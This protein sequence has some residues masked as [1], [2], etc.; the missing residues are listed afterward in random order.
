MAKIELL[1]EFIQYARKKSYQY[2]KK[3]LNSKGFLNK[4]FLENVSQYWIENTDIQ[5]ITDYKSFQKDLNNKPVIPADYIKNLFKKAIL[6]KYI[7]QRKDEFNLFIERELDFIEQELTYIN[8]ISTYCNRQNI[9]KK[10]ISRYFIENFLSNIDKRLTENLQYIENINISLEVT[11]DIENLSVHKIANLNNYK[12]SKFQMT[13]ITQQECLMED[14][15]IKFSINSNKH[16]SEIQYL[17]YLLEQTEFFTKDKLNF[18]KKYIIEL[19]KIK[20]KSLNL[21]STLI[22]NQE[23]EFIERDIDSLENYKTIFQI[24]YMLS[25]CNSVNNSNFLICA[26]DELNKIISILNMEKSNI[27]RLNKII[28]NKSH[29]IESEITKLSF[30]ESG[31]PDSLYGFANVSA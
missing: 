11:S 17:D 22:N 2:T 25:C 31:L 5:K 12:S 7:Q 15:F 4:G 10:N 18:D 21:T 8:N 6:Y 19:I 20:N 9:Y 14:A 30:R 13:N 28:F 29:K 27:D 16:S 1:Q 23:F 3:W 26:N 24:N